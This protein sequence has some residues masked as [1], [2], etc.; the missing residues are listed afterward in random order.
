MPAPWGLR[1]DVAAGPRAGRL[2]PQ[3]RVYYVTHR[4][5]RGTGGKGVAPSTGR[6]WKAAG[7]RCTRRMRTLAAQAMKLL[8][9]AHSVFTFLSNGSDAGRRVGGSP[10]VPISSAFA[11]TR[12]ASR[13]GLAHAS[14]L[15]ADQ[16]DPWPVVQTAMQ[17]ILRSVADRG[18]GY[19]LVPDGSVVIH[20]GSGR[21]GRIGPLRGTSSWRRIRD[22]GRRVRIVLGEVELEKWPKG[23]VEA[24]E[25]VG[26]VVQPADLSWLLL[27]VLE[28]ASQFV[29]NDSGPGHLA[30]IIGVPTVSVFGGT[31]PGVWKPLGPRVKTVGGGTMDAV[32]WMR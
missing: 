14:E 8:T 2:Y 21:P 12:R 4:F 27:K 16:L 28:T 23:E 24:F 15:I 9:S 17:Q 6:I 20:P 32:L 3:S 31:D 30:G 13:L 5:A 18:V 19:R 7:M 10:R 11:P 1:P 29:G 22:A 26:E 25:A